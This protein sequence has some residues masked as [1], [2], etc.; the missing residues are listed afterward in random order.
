MSELVV[1]LDYPEAAPALAMAR[2]LVG[3][4]APPGS[5][6]WVKVGLELYCA[7]GP[8][9]VRALAGMGFPVFVDLK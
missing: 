9:V 8:D 6:V 5:P 3:L 4:G 1:A 2:G 7:A